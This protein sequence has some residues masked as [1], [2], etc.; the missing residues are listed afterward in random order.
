MRWPKKISRD[1]MPTA[2]KE[3]K[4]TGVRFYKLWN[5]I[6][7]VASEPVEYNRGTMSIW[8]HTAY[9][10]YEE[11]GDE[12]VRRP[13]WEDNNGSIHAAA[14]NTQV[15]GDIMRSMLG[16]SEQSICWREKPIEYQ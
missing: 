13:E 11:K 5:P 8:S 7:V 3:W 15:H 10:Y 2:V 6:W 16:Q 1:D 14:I 4:L 9:T 12:F